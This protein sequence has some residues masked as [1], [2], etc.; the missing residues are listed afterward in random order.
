MK[1]ISSNIEISGIEYNS[2][3]EV[4][5]L[6]RQINT[7]SNVISSNS[8]IADS[9]DIRNARIS[10]IREKRLAFF[11]KKDTTTES[12]I[13]TTVETATSDRFNLYTSSSITSGSRNIIDAETDSFFQELI[14]LFLVIV[15]ID[16]DGLQSFLFRKIQQIMNKKVQT[17][18]II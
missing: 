1:K 7:T 10:L 15:L 14:I 4:R 16:G 5:N 18:Q 13:V 3:L 17:L 12:S 2:Y 11:E 8:D 9:I 6:Q